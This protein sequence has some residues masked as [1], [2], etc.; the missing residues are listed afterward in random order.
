ILGLFVIVLALLL[1]WMIGTAGW[2]RVHLSKNRVSVSPTAQLSQNLA[3][4]AQEANQGKQGTVAA[5]TSAKSLPLTV[6]KTP[7]AKPE[8]AQWDG[9]VVNEKGKI[10]YRPPS[11]QEQHEP[12]SLASEIAKDNIHPQNAPASQTQSLA[13]EVAGFY[14]L[15][16]VEPQYPESAR[17]QHIQ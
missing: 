16:R 13:P 10:I 5:E 9:L 8:V 4:A 1:G 3:P 17:T 15:E 12:A 14:L 2:Q 6:S 7:P 11:Q